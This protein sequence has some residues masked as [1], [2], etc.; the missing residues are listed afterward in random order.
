MQPR[1]VQRYS[2]A[3]AE[4]SQH[5]MLAGE[6]SGYQFDRPDNQNSEALT[7]D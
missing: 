4:A 5:L 6:A 1:K 7:M 3:L 2:G